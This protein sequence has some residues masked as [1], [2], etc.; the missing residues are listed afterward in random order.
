M[1]LFKTLIKVA[2]IFCSTVVAYKSTNAQY[3]TLKGSIKDSISGTPIVNAFVVVKK[4][5]TVIAYGKTNLSGEY[6]ITIKLDSSHSDDMQVE[7][8]SIG[9]V[10]S[11]I[12]FSNQKNIYNFLLKESVTVL[13]DV[14]VKAVQ[15]ISQ[16]RYNKISSKRFC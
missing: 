2:F 12:T 11:K 4:T 3:F 6:A 9:Y 14:T 5:I 1:Y 10:P 13:E 16:K 7:V 15:P 8:N